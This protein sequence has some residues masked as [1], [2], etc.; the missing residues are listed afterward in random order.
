MKKTLLGLL[1]LVASFNT[2]A[3]TAEEFFSVNC[4]ACHGEKG[5]GQSDLLTV[6]KLAGQNE[7]YLIKQINDFKS[8]DRVNALMAAPI[9]ALPDNMVEE[10]A[11]YLSMQTKTIG[12]A[13][14]ALVE[15]GQSLYRAGNSETGVPACTACHSP[16]GSGN[17]PGGI[18]S[19]SG[20]HADY[21]ESQLKAYRLGYRDEIPSDSVR[22]NDGETKIMRTIAF[23][24]KDFEIE[25]LSSYINGLH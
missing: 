11:K 20:Q 16:T 23:K 24:L 14:P 2:F 22:V 8:G 13:D 19:L 10:V 9:T 4:V 25:A 1:T 7:K 21:I 15:L 5:K 12:N 3:Q 17:A 6:P 18:P